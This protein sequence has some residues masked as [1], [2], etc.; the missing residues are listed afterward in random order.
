MIKSTYDLIIFQ[1]RMKN[2]D[3][4]MFEHNN[5]KKTKKCC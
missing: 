4:S 5:I 1:N 3:A 2:S